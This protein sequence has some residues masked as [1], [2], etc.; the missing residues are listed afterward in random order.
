M[1][2]RV[3]FLTMMLAALFCASSQA[4]PVLSG[5]FTISGNF[6]ISNPTFNGCP[7]TQCLSWTDPQVIAANKADISSSGLSGVFSFLPGFAGH[8]KANVN[9][10]FTPPEI[11]D[12]PGFAPQPFISFTAPGVST[13]L[14]ID[15][16]AAGVYSPGQCGLGLAPAAGQQWSE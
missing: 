1:M 8:D 16:I 9:N 3:P 12:G 5:T 6:T 14:S 11:V 4:A 10:I 15:F 13:N 7:V 2:L